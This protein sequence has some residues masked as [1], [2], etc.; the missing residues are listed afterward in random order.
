[1]L[2]DRFKEI[3]LKNRKK[4]DYKINQDAGFSDNKLQKTSSAKAERTIYEVKPKQYTLPAT[5]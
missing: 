1:M 2:M 3:I 5:Q 4:K